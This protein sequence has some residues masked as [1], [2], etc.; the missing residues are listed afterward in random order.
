MGLTQTDVSKLYVT[1]FGRASEGE[2]NDYWQKNGGDTLSET[3]DNMLHTQAAEEY[4]GDTLYDNQKF[5]EFIYKNTL[6]KTAEDDP[7]GVAYWT[8]ELNSGKSKGEVV[9]SLVTAVEEHA[10]SDDPLTRSAYE[11]FMNRVKVSDYCADNQWEFTGDFDTFK[12]FS[13]MM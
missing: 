4:F 7:E 3:A 6:G 5:V 1:V 8:E 13:L 12:D 9:A 2:G 11:Q 10:H